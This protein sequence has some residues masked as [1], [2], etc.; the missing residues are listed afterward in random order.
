MVGSLWFEA[1]L[2]FYSAIGAANVHFS[3]IAGNF[4]WIR[5]RKSSALLCSPVL[6]LPGDDPFSC[7]EPALMSPSYL[8]CLFPGSL[9]SSQP[10][11]VM[12]F[13]VLYTWPGYPLL[14]LPHSTTVPMELEPR[15][16]PSS[17]LT[18][19]LFPLYPVNSPVPNVM[20]ALVC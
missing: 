2:F 11:P 8:A 15:M 10:G 18:S 16:E 9:W 4:N 17:Q 3:V 1:G 5:E 6:Y 7:L 13:C 12:S 19:G 20:T 14:G